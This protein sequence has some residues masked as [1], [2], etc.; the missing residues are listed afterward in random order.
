MN[1][2]FMFTTSKKS[3]SFFDTWQASFKDY[4]M[5]ESS[6]MGDILP[7]V[8]NGMGKWQNPVNCSA[9]SYFIFHYKTSYGFGAHVVHWVKLFHV[10]LRT[11]RV[12][13]FEDDHAQFW[14]SQCNDK[15]KDGRH[16]CYFQTMSRTCPFIKV[17]ELVR[18]GALT[19]Y[20]VDGPNMVD[21]EGLPVV[22]IA[23]DRRPS[24]VFFSQPRLAY[25]AWQHMIDI[26]RYQKDFPEIIEDLVQDLKPEV[27]RKYLEPLDNARRTWNSCASFYLTRLRDEIAADI[28]KKLEVLIQVPSFDMSR[29]I[30]LPLRGSDKCFG[31]KIEGPGEMSCV[32]LSKAMEEAHRIAYGQPM[33]THIIITS[34]DRQAIS[35]DRINDAQGKIPF[36]DPLMVIKNSFDDPPGTGNVWMRKGLKTNA[37]FGEMMESSLLSLHLQA[38][39]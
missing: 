5:L 12:F 22:P 16:E 29:V 33:L 38:L 39:A 1:F 31:N 15:E 17:K 4:S 19:R 18:E 2:T 14:M 35:V 25:S 3:L 24:A 27:A 28:R 11:K 23:D 30:G 7:D 34:E 21:L 20:D 10:A 9:A 32:S 13:L 36:H 8:L 6:P 37:T 26:Y